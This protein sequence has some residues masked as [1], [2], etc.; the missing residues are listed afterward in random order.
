M[1]E[2]TN[3]FLNGFLEG[4]K[5]ALEYS[6]RYNQHYSDMINNEIKRLTPPDEEEKGKDNAK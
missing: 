4:L 3:Q 5:F 2:K 6:N 1:A